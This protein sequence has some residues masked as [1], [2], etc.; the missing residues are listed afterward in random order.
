MAEVKFPCS[1]GVRFLAE[2][3]H[4][5][6][7]TI[8]IQMPIRTIGSEIRGLFPLMDAFNVRPLGGRCCSV[9]VR[10]NFRNLR[11]THANHIRM[12]LRV[13]LRS[14]ARA[15]LARA[16]AVENRYVLICSETSIGE[17]VKSLQAREICT[18]LASGD[19]RL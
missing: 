2:L 8:K 6:R 7:L 12:T 19:P 16:K 3:E 15:T 1:L 10:A 17:T 11:P 18:C 9:C 13:H 5:A 4:A 14:N